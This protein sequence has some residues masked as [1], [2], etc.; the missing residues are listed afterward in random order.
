MTETE[1]KSF[2][3]NM[4]LIYQHGSSHSKNKSKL[5]RLLAIHNCHY[6]VEQIL[7]EHGKNISFEGTFNDALHNLNFEE[8]IKRINQKQ[9]IPDYDRLLE[10]NKIRNN[11]EHLFIIP[12]A[13][14]VTI[15]VRI[16]GDFLKWS[17]KTYFDVDYDA[18]AFEDRIYDAPIK[19][20]MLDAKMFIEQNDLPKA[21][22]KMYEALG[23]FK[24]M[25]FGYLSDPR[26]RGISFG[27]ISFT[28]LV[29]D[30]AFKI[31]LS[32]DEAT[33]RKLMLIGT[34]FAEIPTEKGY[35]TGIQ[36]TYSH[37]LFKDKDEASQDYEEILDI[38]LSY[39]DR[40][41]YSMWRKDSLTP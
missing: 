39:Q 30:L 32:E 11:A 33:L 6:V 13:E 16:A 10:L 7:R 29:A 3:T 5:H 23:A 41:P 2:L 21:L 20:A 9:T 26:L 27:G 12:D 31:I 4:K 8:I 15:C 17:Y 19:K 25:W 1:L 18:L 14:S 37:P 22:N 40:I 35:V 34:D 38:I 36:S 28:S 24:F